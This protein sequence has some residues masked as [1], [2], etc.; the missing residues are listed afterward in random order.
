MCF[1]VAEKGLSGPC[2]HSPKAL[3]GTQGAGG[4]TG[5]PRVGATS[6]S[7]GDL[8]RT[9]PMLLPPPC[10]LTHNGAA[11]DEVLF[12]STRSYSPLAMRCTVEELS[13]SM[14]QLSPNMSH[15]REPSIVYE[16][17]CTCNS[18]SLSTL[19]PTWRDTHCACTS[20]EGF[21]ASPALGGT[22]TVAL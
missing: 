3:S 16:T 11:A 19:Q 15:H 20:G 1:S 7:S 10:L 22:A 21:S 2:C 14:S 4:G 9:L 17:A 13:H 12:P 5:I 6:H 8:P 18:R